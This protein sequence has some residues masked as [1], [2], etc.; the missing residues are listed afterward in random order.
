MTRT[1]RRAWVASWFAACVVI[2]L[3][4]SCGET[5]AVDSQVCAVKQALVAGSANADIMA[6]SIA[7]KRAIGRVQASGGPPGFF[8]SGVLVAP[9]WVLTARHCDQGGAFTFDAPGDDGRAPRRLSVIET[10]ANPDHDALLL[11]L[12]A[13][14]AAEP[15]LPIDQAL[16]AARYRGAPVDLAG[17]GVNADGVPASALS[18]LAEPIASIDSE[19]LVVDG[20]G[21]SGACIGDS[22]GPMLLRDGT[23]ALRV[24]G[25][26]SS[27][28]A[29]CTG[30]DRYLRA[31]VIRAWVLG[32]IGAPPPTAASCGAIDSIG[33]CRSDTAIWCN[34]SALH[35]QACSGA[36][37]CGW[38][39]AAAGYR[40]VQRQQDACDGVSDLG[41]CR[42]A[43]LRSCNAGHLDETDCASCNAACG[44][45]ATQGKARC[46]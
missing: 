18:F 3:T 11:R 22:G 5:G 10:H 27:G 19:M 31:D 45:D 36:T 35:A 13:A 26:L 25:I 15:I 7:Q 4:L 20:K 41:E 2:V 23:G 33:F 37:A 30:I 29:A 6:L 44:W 39:N 24:A 17:Y 40:C 28:S 14:V 21:R 46:R 38:S 16:D 32:M 34:S 42:D 12:D 43:T 8:C 9:T 1:P